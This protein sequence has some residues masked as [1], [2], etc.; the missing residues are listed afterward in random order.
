[1]MPPKRSVH[2]YVP[3]PRR[4]ALPRDRSPGFMLSHS[5]EWL[6][7]GPIFYT[8]ITGIPPVPILPRGEAEPD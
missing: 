4:P 8:K 5:A 2:K 6:R 3:F 7:N 1:M